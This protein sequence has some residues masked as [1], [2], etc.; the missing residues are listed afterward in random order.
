MAVDVLD[1]WIGCICWCV[2]V[3]TALRLEIENDRVVVR[4]IHSLE[5]LVVIGCDEPSQPFHTLRIACQ[6]DE[7]QSVREDLVCDDGSVV[8]DVDF[9]N[10][11]SGDFGEKNA[12]EGIGYG[13]IDADE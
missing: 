8:R 6:W 4:S 9:L 13:G 11:Q 3:R 2:W 12:P 1:T 10:C 7:T 5:V